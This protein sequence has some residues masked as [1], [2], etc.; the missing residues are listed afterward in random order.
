MANGNSAP[1]ESRHFV[2]VHGSWHGSWCWDKLTPLLLAQGH[3]VTALDLPGRGTNPADLSKVTADDYVRTVT[4]VLDQSTKPVI[5]VGHSMGGGII[6]LAAETRFD[7]IKTLVYLTAF[8]LTD[9]QAMT[10]VVGSDTKSIL[11]KAVVRDSKL[12]VSYLK[13]EFVREVFYH[14]CTNAD[15]EKAQKL[16][17]TEPAVMG[18]AP[19]RTTSQ[20]FGKVDRVYI[21]CLQDKAISIDLQRAMQKALPCRTVLSLDTGHSAFFANPQALAKALLSV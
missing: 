9:G 7:K 16:V 4:D 17:V 13:P 14:D 15:V 12:G 10:L 19:I 5:L 18:R 20:R 11:H 21:E 8:L 3:Q 2:L 6:S 1:A